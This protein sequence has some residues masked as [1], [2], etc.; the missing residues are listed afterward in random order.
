MSDFSGMSDADLLAQY[1]AAQAKPAASPID[2]A[3]TAEGIQGPVA[4]I[5]RSIYQQESGSGKNTKTSNA[6]AVGGMQIIPSTFKSVADKDWNINDPTQNARAGV[7]Y[8]EQL[9]QQAGGDPALTAAGY[10]G[11]PGGLEK[12][13][14]GIAVADP[15]NPNAPT[16]LQYGQQVAARLPKDQGLVAKIGNAVTDAIIPSANAG[17]MPQPAGASPFAKMSDAD[18]LAQYKAA[19]AAPDTPAAPP[20]T[21][22]KIAAGAGRFA[23][24]AVQGTKDLAAGAVRG[25]GSIGATL[26]APVDIASDAL[27]GKGLTLASND[28]RRADMDS[29][30]K[31]LGANPDS[32]AYKAGKLGT[33]I[34]GTAGTGGVLAKGAQAVGAA[35]KIV[36]ALESGGLTLGGAPAT[37]ATEAAG[38]LL[39]RAGAGAATGATSAGLVDPK[40]AKTGAIV[41]GA[42][43]VGVA[44]LGKAGNALGQAI[45]GGGVAPEVKALADRAKQLGID[46]P[47]DRLVN[48]KPL[49][50]LGASLEYVPLSGRAGT[51][52]KMEDQLNTAVSR[53][54]GQDS[55]N[56]TQALR[57]AGDDLGGKFDNVL[58]SNT[59][60]IDKPFLDDLAEAA[61]KAT[62]ELAPDQAGIIGRQV[63]NLLAKGANGEIDGQAAYNIKK[64]LDQI[65]KRNSPEAY[66]ALDLKQKLMDALNRSLGP[67]EAAAF[68]T[69]REQYG[70]MLSME[71]IAQN[72]AEGGVSIARL[73]NM[74]NI[75]NPQLQELADISSQFLKNRESAHGAAQ[76]VFGGMGAAGTAA[77]AAMLGHAAVPVALAGGMAAGR[78]ANALL[79]SN[80]ARAAILGGPQSNLLLQ[81]A[82]AGQ[83]ALRAAP[84][85]ISAR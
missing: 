59:V 29:A 60:K 44:A 16:T 5:A 82:N 41:G 75:N 22:D 61:N 62:S 1:K 77:T 76:R 4:D 12:A 40:D 13:R 81:G 38:N 45:T 8:I 7:R 10:Y 68:K 47:A 43:P 28:Q 34:A 79:N 23:S 15:R 66:Y 37:T 30:L 48:S 49:N 54:F 6:G 11:G 58:K 70:N 80:M 26:L 56:V 39:T 3:L 32:L 71:K 21:L 69:T 51:M 78:G 17:E 42:L 31:E 46:I 57:K 52:N 20:S 24:G 35:P 14:Q 85:A 19:K 53:T 55:S 72:G 50:A 74:R 33:E 65:G 64:T 9:Y 73:A 27:A 25:A 36:S 84:V 83:A 67:D 2:A 63:D 18:L